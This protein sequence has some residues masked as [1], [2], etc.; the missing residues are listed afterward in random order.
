MKER[1]AEIKKMSYKDL[2]KEKNELVSKYLIDSAKLVSSGNKNNK[3]TKDIKREIAWVETFIS[4]K[5]YT[6]AEED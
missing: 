1:F 6:R 2:L 5:I 3:K 4:E